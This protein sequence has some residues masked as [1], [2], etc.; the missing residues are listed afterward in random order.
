MALVVILG[1]GVV[2]AVQVL[3]GVDLGLGEVVLGHC[4]VV[5]ALGAAFVASEVASV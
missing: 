1:S 4:L 2:R 3:F 5:V